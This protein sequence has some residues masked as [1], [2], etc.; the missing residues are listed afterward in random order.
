MLGRQLW[1]RFFWKRGAL[2]FGAGAA[3]RNFM[4]ARELCEGGGWVLVSAL[5]H[6]TSCSEGSY[7]HLV[8]LGTGENGVFVSG[9]L[10]PKF[11][12]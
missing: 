9:L 11:E 6:Q 12:G 5:L 4:L 8:F 7:R 10:R 1:A 2:C 3:S